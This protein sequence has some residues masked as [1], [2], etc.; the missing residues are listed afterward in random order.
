MWSIDVLTLGCR[1]SIE[2]LCGPILK[3]YQFP[4]QSTKFQK[5]ACYFTEVSAHQFIAVAAPRA[6]ITVP[7]YV[8]NSLFSG[9][10]AL[11]DLVILHTTC[12]QEHRLE[13]HWLQEICQGGPVQGV[14]RI[15]IY[16]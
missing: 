6:L 10:K 3:F 12:D 9:A 16:G 13:L 4:L 11:S 2:N 7:K 15:G 5:A 8:S 14:Q 1:K